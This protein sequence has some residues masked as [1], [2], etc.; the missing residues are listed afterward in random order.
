[1]VCDHK[2]IVQLEC[3]FQDEDNLYFLM[4]YANKGSLSSLIKHIHPLPIET[5]RYF[6]AEL[7]LAL[8]Y[9]H[10]Q[11][12][13]HRDLK[14]ENI[15][16][17]EEY[18]LKLCDFGEAKI[19]KEINF[20][21]IIKDFEK[22]HKKQTQASS[23]DEDDNED[24]QIEAFDEDN[25]DDA[26]FGGSPKKKKSSNTN[27]D[28]SEEDYDDEDPFDDLFLE[29][30]KAYNPDLDKD[31]DYTGARMDHRGTF[32][33]TPLYATPEMLESSISGPF[34]DLWALG[35]IAYQI[36][37]GETPWKGLEYAIFE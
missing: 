35:V 22:F 7:V 18:H 16:L 14:P 36:I 29:D 10:T 8:E 31:D 3:T 23:K 28:A 13:S 6:I 21:Q 1:M 15:L 19:I 4:E 37:V 26:F 33:G 32:V 27:Q 25:F 2:N 12:I 30:Q 24:L 11:N 34:T 5:C 17:D 20:E 9:L